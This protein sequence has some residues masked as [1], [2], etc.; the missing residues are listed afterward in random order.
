MPITL[1]GTTG[2]VPASWTTAGRPSS[3]V[4]GQTGFNTTLGVMETYNGTAWLVPGRYLLGS[5]TASGV[6]NFDMTGWYS[7]AFDEYEI[8][9]VGITP[10]TNAVTINM[11][12]SSDSGS[13]Y[14]SGANYNQ[15]AL[16]ATS[17]TPFSAVSSS[18]TTAALAGAVSNSANT[19]LSATMKLSNQSGTYKLFIV[20]LAY[21]HTT[22]APFIGILNQYWNSTSV[23]NG[24]RFYCSSGNI[25]GDV[26]IYGMVK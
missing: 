24:L 11:R 3:P 19:K 17:G 6:A 14:D 22:P 4:A 26:R 7:S 5:Y 16:L 20:T 25:S 21:Q 15:T 8:E 2:E 13:S 12:C 1:N 10:A 18:Q 23:C 9:L